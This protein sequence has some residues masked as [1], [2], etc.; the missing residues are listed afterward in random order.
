[1]M[2]LMI[3]ES[4]ELRRRESAKLLEN[5]SKQVAGPR[6]SAQNYAE[7]DSAAS[8]LNSAFWPGTLILRPYQLDAV[9]QIRRAA[10]E[11]ASG[12]ILQMPTGAGKTACFADV[13]KGAHAKGRCAIMV[14]RGK[15]LVHQASERL[16]REDV[17]HGIY[18]GANSK[19]THERILVCSVDTLFARKEAPKAD[20]IVIDECHLSHSAGYRWLLAQY[21]SVFKLGVSATPHHKDGMRHIGDR[22]VNPVGINE[23]IHSGYLVGGRYFVPYVPNLRGVKKN[24]GDFS[25]SD[26]GKRSFEDTELTANAAKVWAEHLRGKSTL[27]YAVSIDHAA[28]L[29][30]A[31]RGVGARCETVVASTPDGIRRDYIGWLENGSLDA[32]I[33]IGVLTT[34]VDIPSLRAILCCRPTE[35]YNLWIQILGRGTRPNLGKS[36]FLCYD[37]S[38]NILRHGPIE[39]ELVGN[40]DGMPATKSI[41]IKICPACYA[42]FESGP[43][44]CPACGHDMTVTKPRKTGKRVHGLTDNEEIEEYRVKEWELRLPELVAKAQ[45]RGFRKGWIYNSLKSEFGDDTANEAWPRIRALKKWPIKSPTLKAI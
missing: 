8:S 1:M 45:A 25:A 39:A 31:L 28:V 37:L 15:Q 23:L 30:G 7:I 16:T 9:F 42:T 44:E 33:S 18:Q 13:L 19:N 24:N 17:P 22:L 2:A 43:S 35:S 12:A 21:P 29:L 20:L 10:A 40:L 41:A 27:V 4:P 14:V 3:L 6:I 36:H 5:N 32:I 26:L 34:G 11:K 38:G